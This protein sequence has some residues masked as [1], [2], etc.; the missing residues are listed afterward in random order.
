[1]LGCGD[2]GRDGVGDGFACDTV[3]ALA[4]ESHYGLRE[5]SVHRLPQYTR[6]LMT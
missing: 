6:G 2:G 4:G 1:M 3:E 5:G